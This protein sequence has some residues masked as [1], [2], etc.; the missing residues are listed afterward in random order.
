M[1]I[2]GI[3]M[4]ALSGFYY[5]E[6]DDGFIE[7]RARGKL[8]HDK[9]MPLVGDHVKIS[10]TEENQ[11]ILE[12]VL[13]RKNSFI[14]PSVANIDQMVIIASETIPVTDPFLIDRITAIAELRGCE[15]LIVINK[16]DLSDEKRLF[17]VY[18]AA[19][20]T[21]INVSAVDR[22]GIDELA[23]ALKGKINAFTGNSGVGKSSILNAL[24]DFRIETGEVSHKLGRGR[25]TTTH[26]ELY[27]LINGAIIADTPGFAAFDSYEELG[28]KSELQFA[29]RDFK[30]YIEN[31]Q[32]RGC[33]HIKEHGC[34]LIEALNEGKILDSRYSS[35]VRLFEQV[36]Q[37]K[38]WEVKK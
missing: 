32:Y 4:K 24:Q 17:D 3:I 25:H 27:K 12:E 37:I 15:P 31:C 19:G 5:V 22:T 16:C 7:C 20:F 18:C 1:S 21:T 23:D 10:L 8:R 34:S 26:V 9:I 13:P 28:G 29:F 33:T 36:K 14:R 11:G 2:E 30:P 35:Y 6:T 38:E